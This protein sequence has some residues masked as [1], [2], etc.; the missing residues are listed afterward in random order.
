MDGEVKGCQDQHTLQPI[1]CQSGSSGGGISEEELRRQRER[2][3]QE[4]RARAARRQRALKLYKTGKSYGGRRDYV[5]A[6]DYYRKAV[7]ALATMK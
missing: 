4:Q 1:E 7:K 2:E 6:S 5:R 3:A